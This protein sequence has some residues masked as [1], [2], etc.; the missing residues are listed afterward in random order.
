MAGSG[1]SP[2][3]DRDQPSASPSRSEQSATH[4]L[5]LIVEDNAADALLIIRAIKAAKLD[6]DM[7]VVKDGEQAVEFL[8]AAKG[9]PDG[10]RP[11]L[12]ILDINLPKMQGSE[13]L[14]HMRKSRGWSD[15]PV[16]AVSTS[17]S[18][19]DRELMTKLG[20][21]QYFR[22]P[23]AYAEFMKL[24]DRIRDLLDSQSSPR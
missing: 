5:I 17:D 23:S 22:K 8:D 15:V 21:N 1:S 3:S 6:A 13:V 14:Q 24:G 2:N 19:H 20:A 7:H 12:V 10:R 9:G 16:I 4:L 18:A 11:S